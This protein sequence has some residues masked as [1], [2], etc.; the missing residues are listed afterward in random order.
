MKKTILSLAFTTLLLTSC[1]EK[2][3]EVAAEAANA[4]ASELKD[5][6]DSTASKAEEAIDSA[7][8]KAAN[9]VEASAAKLE[10]TA[11]KAKEEAK[12]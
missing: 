3:Q 12:K 4:V 11:K 7:T 10:E 6:V 9:A 2:T 5:A 8:S 1:K